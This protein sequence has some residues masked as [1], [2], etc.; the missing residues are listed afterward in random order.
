MT[1]TEKIAR[2]FKRIFTHPDFDKPAKHSR[3][4]GLMPDLDSYLKAK[5][6]VH[7]DREK[8]DECLRVCYEEPLLS[9]EQEQHVFRKFNFLKYQA[10]QQFDKGDLDGAERLLDQADECRN[11]LAQANVRLAI[12]PVKRYNRRYFEDLLGEA[13]FLIVKAV[14]YFDWTRGFKFSTYARWTI[15]KTLSQ[16]ISN[17][18]GYDMHHQSA[19]DLFIENIVAGSDGY[20]EELEHQR[21]IRMVLHLLEFADPRERLILKRRFLKEETLEEVGKPLNITKER[22]RQLQARGIQQIRDRADT[23]LFLE[24]G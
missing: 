2:H 11:L 19:D 12:G 17:M 21:M 1:R 7:K 18:V 14:D 5:I 20:Q 3:I 23:G 16:S 22:V 10:K 9:K 15:Y 13:F 24:I 4:L 6:K 8:A